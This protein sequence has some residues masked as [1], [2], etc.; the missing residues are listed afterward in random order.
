MK[1]PLLICFL[2][3]FALIAFAED[4]KAE[5]ETEAQAS[6]LLTGGNTSVTTIGAGA[7]TKY[8]PGD[9]AYS[10]AGNFLTSKNS[11][12][13]TAEEVTASL[14]AD[15]SL[16]ETASLF[17]NLAYLQNFFAGFSSRYSADLGYSFG[18]FQNDAHKLNGEISFGYQ[19]ERRTSGV[20][21]DFL[22]F[23]SALIYEYVLSKTSKFSSALRF[24]ENL[25]T[26]SDWRLNWDN[27]LSVRMTEM[28]SLQVGFVVGHLNVPV[29]GKLKTDTA[30]TLAV[31]ANF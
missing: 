11:G 27:S 7:K 2:S 15:R 21:N 13:K 8:K 5:W 6:V 4:D 29:A 12:N 9:W 25:E 20:D 23:A 16:T 18:I 1:H 17:A 24:K 22:N 31:V 10:G 14:R 3:L 28:L 26:T 19:I 30:T